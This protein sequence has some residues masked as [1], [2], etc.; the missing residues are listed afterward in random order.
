MRVALLTE[1]ARPHPQRGAGDWCDRPAEGLPEHEFAW[2]RP[3]GPQGRDAVE[4]PSPA[5]C[6]GHR[7]A[8]WGRPPG[9]RAPGA[10]RR[11]RHAGAYEQ[12]LRALV[13]PGERAGF[14]PGPYR[15][16]AL[17]RED[18][19]LP[20]FPASGPARRPLVPAR[21]PGALAGACPPPRDEERR[22]RLGPAGR[23]RAQERFA[24]EPVIGAFR[25]IHPE[26]VPRYPAFLGGGG[27]VAAAL[28]AYAV[29]VLGRADSHR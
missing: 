1:G 8:P 21:D 9:G 13:L 10:R 16:A 28:P 27:A 14:G 29:V 4:R 17:A 11:R 5:R 22:G 18:G 24:V 19:T 25:E 12:L 15:L 23:P 6:G 20:A 3:A 26:L 2:Y 7:G